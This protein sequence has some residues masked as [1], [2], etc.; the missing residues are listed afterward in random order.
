[1]P[2][3]HVCAYAGTHVAITHVAVT[4]L[5]VTHVA[6][7]HVAVTHVAATYVA[8]PMWRY[9]AR[10]RHIGTANQNHL[11]PLSRA[12]HSPRLIFFAIALEV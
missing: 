9:L 6:V 4:H 12:C 8:L 7:T 3:L 10:Y 5:A 11:V 2:G 1:M